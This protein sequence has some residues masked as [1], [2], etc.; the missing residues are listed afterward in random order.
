MI[1]TYLRNI[2][3]DAGRSLAILHS[4]GKAVGVTSGVVIS[5]G[6]PYTKTV[7]SSV[8]EARWSAAPGNFVE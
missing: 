5:N 2:F 4:A 3:P 6:L 7:R 1:F 8:Q